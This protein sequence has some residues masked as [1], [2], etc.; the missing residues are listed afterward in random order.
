VVIWKLI[1]QSGGDKG[2]GGNKN[3]RCNHDDILQLYDLNIKKNRFC[4]KKVDAST[5]EDRQKI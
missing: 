3:I 2:Q 1:R 4:L 5:L